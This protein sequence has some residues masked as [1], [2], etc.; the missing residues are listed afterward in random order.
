MLCLLSAGCFHKEP[1]H[2]QTVPDARYRAAVAESDP[3]QFNLPAAG[4][5]EEAAMLKALRIC[6][7]IIAL[8][9]WRPT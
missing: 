6:L 7:R 8:L 5:P 9:I 3:A 2:T 1:M 4:S